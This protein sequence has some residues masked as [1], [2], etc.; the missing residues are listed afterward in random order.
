M[1]NEN[2]TLSLLINIL[3]NNT[4]DVNKFEGFGVCKN[5]LSYNLLRRNI[6]SESEIKTPPK[7]I[8][9]YDRLFKKLSEKLNIDTEKLIRTVS[10]ISDT[11]FYTP[12]YIA[13]TILNNTINAYLL[14]SSHNQNEK[15]I[16]RILEPSS[17]NG[18][19]LDALIIYAKQNITIDLYIDM[20]EMCP[21]THLLLNEKI[22]ATEIPKNIFIKTHNQAFEE[23]ISKNNYDIVLSNIPFGSEKIEYQ[24][25]LLD[26]ESLFFKKGIEHLKDNG[27]L[28]YITGVGFL[29][30]NEAEE[31][32]KVLNQYNV[33]EAGYFPHN[34]FDNTYV[35]SNLVVIQKSKPSRNIDI[36]QIQNIE[37]TE[38][39]KLKINNLLINNID[40]QPIKGYGLLF[41]NDK[42]F[43]NRP[44]GQEWH[45]KTTFDVDLLK[46]DLNYKLFNSLNENLSTTQIEIQNQKSPEKESPKA[47][48]KNYQI[49]FLPI[50]EK[51]M[52]IDL[53]SAIKPLSEKMDIH[54]YIDKL[55]KEKN[56]NPIIEFSQD[57]IKKA[58]LSETKN[59]S[60]I[61]PEFVLSIKNNRNETLMV[62]YLLHIGFEALP[63]F[64]APINLNI[65]GKDLESNIFVIPNK[66]NTEYYIN[67]EISKFVQKLITN[68]INV[69]QLT[70]EYNYETNIVES[71]SNKVKEYNK[72]IGIKN[73]D[74]EAPK[75]APKPIEKTLPTFIITDKIKDRNNIGVHLKKIIELYE[76]YLSYNNTNKEE[77]KE[78][79]IKTYSEIKDSY[80]L[81][82]DRKNKTI[83]NNYFDQESR[84]DLLALEIRIG[85]KYVPSYYIK[86][87]VDYSLEY[88][89]ITIKDFY[90]YQ[91][92]NNGKF[93]ISEIS[94]KLNVTIEEIEKDLFE[95][96]IKD[97][98]EDKY[99]NK[100]DLL[101]G[102]LYDNMNQY[103][104]PKIKEFIKE[105]LPQKLTI[106]EISPKLGEVWLGTEVIEGF[107]LE[108]NQNTAV[109]SKLIGEQFILDT[110]T[111]TPKL[112]YYKIPSLSRD[113]N[114]ISFIEYV[115]EGRRPP[116]S[117]TTLDGKRHIDRKAIELF[118]QKKE[119]LEENFNRYINSLSSD[120][121]EELEDK[122]NYLFNS[123]IKKVLNLEHGTVFNDADFSN[124]AN[125]KEFRPHQV[126]S[127]IIAKQRGGGLL[128]QEVGTGKTLIMC[129]TAHLMI[130]DNSHRR[131]VLSCMKANIAAIVE[132]YVKLYPNDK[133]MFPTDEDLQKEN[134]DVFFKRLLNSDAKVLFLTH[135]QLMYLPINE[136]IEIEYIQDQIRNLTQIKK[137]L[138]L[139]NGKS[140]DNRRFLKNLS[141]S[142]ENLENK[143]NI[144]IETIN[145]KKQSISLNDLEIDH[146]I[147]DEAHKYKNMPFQTRHNNVKG[148]NKAEGSQRA[149]NLMLQIEDIRRRKP[150]EIG[151]TLLTGTPINNSVCEIYAYARLLMPN[152]LEK[153]RI[154]SF[155]SFART[156]FVKS[157]ELEVTIGGNEMKEEER[158]RQITKAPELAKLY[159]LFSNII[160]ADDIGI[161]RPNIEMVNV[162]IEPDLYMINHL[163]EIQNFI[164]SGNCQIG[165]RYF[166]VQGIKSS[167]MLEA[168]TLMQK[169]TTDVRLLC[170]TAERGLS[171]LDYMIK[172][173]HKIYEDTK[174][175]KGT[176]IIYLDKGVP[177][178]SNFNLYKIIK[179][180]LIERGINENEIAF[181]H[182]AKTHQHK[183]ALYERMNQGE[184]RILLASRAKG[185]VG[186]NVQ[187]KG[188]AIHL[189]D[190]QWNP[191]GDEQ[192]IA[193]FRRQGNLFAPNHQ[194]NIVKIYR[195]A[196]T[197][198]GDLR[199]LLTSDIKDRI[200]F[201]MR[202]SQ[203]IERTLD[204]GYGDEDSGLGQGDF[205]AD[206]QGDNRHKTKMELETQIIKLGNRIE[207]NRLEYQRKIN[208]KN[209]LSQSLERN[210]FELN[211]I[212]DIIDSK[213]ENSKLMYSEELKT[214]CLQKYTESKFKEKN[215]KEIFDK[216]ELKKEIIEDE[217]I[218]CTP[219]NRGLFI[220]EKTKDGVNS[221]ELYTYA[222]FEKYNL[223]INIGALELQDDSK[224]RVFPILSRYD[225]NEI[226]SEVKLGKT[227]E[228]YIEN[229]ENRQA[230]LSNHIKLQKDELEATN[231]FLEKYDIKNLEKEKDSKESELYQL[232]EEMRKEQKEKELNNLKEKKD[233]EI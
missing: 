116:F 87:D 28:S 202:S 1:L 167:K 14:K 200:I 224:N 79:L 165:N 112:N 42:L 131:V 172:N 95:Y 72:S 114:A 19:F 171:K 66:Y 56:V 24:N 146:I 213:K 97:N 210:E 49:S 70:L 73:T 127:A 223:K 39:I 158:F 118:E 228:N 68:D 120:K 41:D 103:Q 59:V 205:L 160:R 25:N 169:L 46:T 123:N 69:S 48:N 221:K 22:N 185:G 8:E 37:I 177:N 122:Y 187:Q 29:R 3:D 58:L 40:N 88:A 147:V 218:Y 217:E 36:N 86:K 21:V 83:I 6:V 175:N 145:D 107:L 47:S 121:K 170:P 178:S 31:A 18:I 220:K 54:Y 10:N 226:T 109:Y 33:I 233:N 143:L 190:T 166:E 133:I 157:Y 180:D 140:T 52:E 188:A 135:E 102:N 16:I 203:N 80:G 75:K 207:A 34:M 44:T 11:Q 126:D 76:N 84:S 101:I 5:L 189:V 61:R 117:Y 105:N 115:M 163:K 23:Y 194:N 51:P 153:R 104:D 67:R 81:L 201:A 176:Q 164:M 9:L 199:I 63:F 156:F 214:F 209:A 100:I 229:L 113:L 50:K 38:K 193:R 125:I 231:N 93:D 30:K 216:I 195:Y 144:K 196:Y 154:F 78:K 35:N 136:E 162:K 55:L 96:I 168:T 137:E 77:N 179:K 90:F 173:V 65:D 43:T 192:A 174:E 212:Q 13:E 119:E 71:I 184:V 183:D 64:Y 151:A 57:N 7:T 32:R 139:E 15:N 141:E 130:R 225:Y 2:Q 181:I 45:Y 98:S 111:I 142:I 215:E 230:I 227:F 124:F 89:P 108:L 232:K 128:D 219:K 211:F 208:F 92:N 53:F 106:E 197:N 60:E 206:L 12:S 132:D 159:Q 182:D 198:S 74:F 17:G 191:S 27:V 222:S 129:L 161:E 20:V 110:E 85:T 4:N 186:I 204:E 99:Y 134:R 148:L 82:N 94:K 150:S 155:D 149:F 138:Q 91:I 62:H 152:E 26:I